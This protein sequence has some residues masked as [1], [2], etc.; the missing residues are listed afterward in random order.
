M[1]AVLV[2]IETRGGE[3]LP[4]SYELLA[5]ARGLAAADGYEVEALVA[6]ADPTALAGSLVA[7]DRVLTVAHPALSPYSPQ[8]HAAVVADVVAQR[9]PAIALFGYSA[10]GLDLAP[11]AAAGGEAALVAY[12]TDLALEDGALAATSQLYGGKLAAKSRSSLPAVAAV[13]PGRFSEDAGRG[14]AGGTVLSVA[15]PAALDGLAVQVVGEVL[16]DAGGVDL[17]AAD[18]ILCVGRGIGDKD[19]I[20]VAAEVAGLLGAELAGSR[21]IIDNGW[22]EKARQ[23]GKSGTKVKPKLYIAVGVSGAPEHLEGMGSAELIVAVNSDAQAPIFAVAHFGT[24]CD[25]FDLLPAVAE[26]LRQ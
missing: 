23:V 7:A 3:V 1:A 8:A 19:K 10:A 13:V 17:T 20:E 24:T 21:P 2:Y 5:A 25:L 26:R 11:A 18:K 14:G 9:R 4:I 12:A 22:L 16:P 15:P 6:A